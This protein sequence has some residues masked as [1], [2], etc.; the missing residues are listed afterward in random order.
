MLTVDD[1]TVLDVET[2][3]NCNAS[4]ALCL[5]HPGMRAHDTL[6]WN[7]II[8]HM[9]HQLW[10]Q[11]STINFNGTTGDNMLHPN[12]YN[13]IEWTRINS[14]A[15]ISIHTNGSMRDTN[16][17]HRLGALL[18][19][20]PHRVVFG[21]DGLA[22]THAIYRTGTNWHKIIDNA[23]AF[24]QGGG[25]AQWQFILFKHNAHQ[26][27]DARKISQDLNFEK[28]FVLHQDRFNANDPSL[29]HLEPASPDLVPATVHFIEKD[30][31]KPVSGQ[32]VCE[33]KR[34][35]WLSIYADAT[36]W[37]CCWLMGWHR[38]Q[39]QKLQ[40]E[41]VNYHFKNTLK[42]DFDQISLY[43]NTLEDILSG[44]L[45]QNRYPNSFAQ[46]PNLIC[47][48]RCSK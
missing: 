27:A 1:V 21:I 33:S 4:C 39:H 14:D 5:R 17:W 18:H 16:W 37:P 9:P 34:T 46:T 15:Y 30:F 2:I 8:Q 41:V 13:I 28:F 20:T 43:T 31:I 29:A 25:Q 6:D 40:Y 11:L 10:R 45:W 48:Q 7:K 35:G 24:I 12:I 38:A 44:D 42:I 19:G 32:I 26:I 22:D 36:V 47:T 23:K 3:N